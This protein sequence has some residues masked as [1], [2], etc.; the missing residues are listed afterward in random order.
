MNEN[1]NTTQTLKHKK[2]SLI[3]LRCFSISRILKS[4]PKILHSTVVFN[5]ILNASVM[6]DS[7]SSQKKTNTQL[8]KYLYLFQK[9]TALHKAVV[10]KASR[11]SAVQ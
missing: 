3:V 9:Q 5:I 1:T 11:R 7:T 4:F 8:F 10:H 6:Q 2:T